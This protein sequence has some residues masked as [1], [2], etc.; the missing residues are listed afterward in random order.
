MFVLF[1]IGSS[2]YQQKINL[3]NLSYL[4]LKNEDADLF[5]IIAY[6]GWVKT[7]HYKMSRTNGSNKIYFAITF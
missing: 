2:S 3:T 6:Q 7:H 1:C 4:D 5:K